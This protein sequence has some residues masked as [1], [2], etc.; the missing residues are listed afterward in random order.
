MD[1]TW[2][3]FWRK[4]EV[5]PNGCWLWTAGQFSNGYGCFSLGTK[6]RQNALAHRFC[7]E[8]FVGAIP[9]DKELDHLCR[10]RHCVNPQH[11]EPVT[12]SE[13]LLR[14][15]ILAISHRKTHCRRGHPFE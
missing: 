8:K 7:Y 5:I 2:N 10:V 3:R 1:K 13:N 6:P 11:L 12:R 9:D 15:P 4:V 14:S